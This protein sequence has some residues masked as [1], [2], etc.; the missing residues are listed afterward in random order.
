MEKTKDEDIK[1]TLNK[2]NE[3]PKKPELIVIQN[4][5]CHFKTKDNSLQNNFKNF[6]EHINK[7]RK[8]KKIIR[9]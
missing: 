8:E 5:K 7:I 4:K 1:E 9:S 2:D 3:D 6:R